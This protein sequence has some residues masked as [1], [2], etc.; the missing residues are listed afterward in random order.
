MITLDVC[1]EPLFTD[2]PAEERIARVAKHGYKS[3][4]FWLHDAG[5]DG[6]G[7][8]DTPRDPAAIRQACE[9]AGV[10]LNNIVVNPPDDGSIGGAPVIAATHAKYLE[11]VE[12]AIAFAQAAG[13]GKAITCAGD[14]QPGMSR[15]AMRDT[16]T[17]AL[18]DAAKIAEKRGF[19][20][21]LEP[22]NTR[23]DHKGYCMSSSQEAAEMVRTINN[24]HLRLLFDVYHMQIME[25][26][27]VSHILASRDVIGHY[28]SAAVPGRGEHDRGELNYPFIL[29][30]IDGTGYK[31]AFGLEY[32]PTVADH[33]TSLRRVR[34][35]LTASGVC[36]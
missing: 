27:V 34:D 20:L 4:E 10:T 21:L 14:E 7:F 2:L 5:F 13:C 26:D 3:V 35:Y 19:T 23:V 22:L 32:F 33:D 17:G 12:A 9:A 28:H 30:A 25:G 1:I 29:E 24:P 18:A 36:E 8:T 11:R 15:E 31:G 6:K 16:V